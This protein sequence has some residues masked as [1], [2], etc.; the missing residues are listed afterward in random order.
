MRSEMSRVIVV[1]AGI[2]GV[3]AAIELKK[4]GHRVILI[5]PGP[6]P[7]P[8]AASTDI[9]KAVRAAYGAD[10]DYTALAELAREIWRRWNVEFGAELY[11]EIGFLFIRQR[12][13]QP[14]DFEYES[15]K[16]LEQRSHRIERISSK[17]LLERFPAWNAERYPDG[18]LD[19]E[20]GYAESGR[21]VATLIQRAKSLGVEL[22]QT[23]KFRDLDETSGRVK[24]ILLEHGE[25]IAADTVVMA[26]G[27]GTPYALPFTRNFFRASGQPVFHLKP[28]KPELFTPER[29]PIFGADIST[30]G[31]YGF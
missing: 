7:H 29:F 25:K 28:E 12:P 27:A 31:Y 24:G 21:V 16:L 23:T 26:V 5:D 13:M 2:N 1:G 22:H 9:S 8:L 4:R 20:A 15:F 11:H 6:L 18:F 3:T 30:T 19:L 17:Q 10:E 14:G